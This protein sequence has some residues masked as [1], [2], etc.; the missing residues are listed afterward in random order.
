MVENEAKH[1]RELIKAKKDRLHQLEVKEAR[2]GLDV[3]PHIS[4]EIEELRSE[5]RDLQTQLAALDKERKAARLEARRQEEARLEAARRVPPKPRRPV[6]WEKVGAVLGVI[7][8]VIALGA[9]LVPNAAD[10][11]SAWLSDTSTTIPTKTPTAIATAT[12]R[13]PTD[14]PTMTPTSSPTHTLVISTATSTDTPFPP[15]STVP[16]TP[17]AT[18][19]PIP[20]RTRAPTATPTPTPTRTR[21]PAATPTPSYIIEFEADKTVADPGEWI[22]LRW[23]V[24]NAQAVYLDWKGGAGAAGSGLESRQVWET[25]D[26][27]LRVVLQNGETVTRTITIIVKQ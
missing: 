3:P 25:T 2:Y 23:H 18:P 4:I 20:T 12:P 11:L 7:A 26:H 22:T 17:T 6:S 24:E 21:A 27:T 19:T 1:L 8:I 9:W 16:P 13:P 14:M 15:T 10:F 5:I